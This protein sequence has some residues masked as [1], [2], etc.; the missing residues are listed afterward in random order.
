MKSLR[1][2]TDPYFTKQTYEDPTVQVNAA[3]D[4]DTKSTVVG[5]PSFNSYQIALSMH[6]FFRQLRL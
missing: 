3:F 2:V 5:R 4:D 1:F 6:I